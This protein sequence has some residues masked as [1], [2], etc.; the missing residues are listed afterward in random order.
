MAMLQ[1]PAIAHG[2]MDFGVLVEWHEAF[3][4]AQV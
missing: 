3:C 2:P 1:D 4:C